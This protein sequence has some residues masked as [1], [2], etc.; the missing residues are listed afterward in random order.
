MDTLSESELLVLYPMFIPGWV[1]PVKPADIAHGGIPK[2]LY[3][4]Q[5]KG[6]E[7]LVDPWTELQMR[8]WTMAV[9]DRVDLYCNGSLV[10][11]AGQTVKP[12]EETLRQRLYLPHGNLK[13]GVNR[14]HYVVTRPGGGFET[15]R[16]LLVLYH[17]R[18]PENL[19]LVIPPDVIANGVDA[20]RAASGVEFGF[21]YANRQNHDRIEFRLGNTQVRFDVPDGTAPITHTLFTDTFQKVGDNLSAVVEFYVD[22]LL[23]NRVNSPEKRLYI[24]L[25]VAVIVPTLTNVLDT[26]GNEVQEAGTT[27]ST[28]LKLV[29]AASKGKE[30]EI[31]DGSGPS[32]VPKGKATADATTGVWELTITVAAGAH[33]LYAKSLYHSSNVY[34]NVRTLTVEAAIAPTIDSVK[35]DGV[36][37][38]DNTDT[39]STSVSLQGIVTSGRQVQIYDGTTPKHTVTAVGTTWST[40]LATPVGSYSITAKE[41]STGQV[42]NTRSFRVISPTLPLKIASLTASPHSHPHVF[43][44]GSGFPRTGFNGARF[45]IDVEAGVPP[46]TFSSSSGVNQIDQAGIVTIRG[47][48]QT[49]FTVRD[50]SGATT[51][52]TMQSLPLFFSTPDKYLHNYHY[53]SNGGRLPSIAQMTTATIGNPTQYIRAVGS[54]FGEWGNLMAGYGWPRGGVGAGQHYPNEHHYWT[55]QPTPDQGNFYVVSPQAGSVGALWRDWQIPCT[56]II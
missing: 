37:V 54:L 38:P 20:A 35:G 19:D 2:A 14:L 36:E 45:R 3:D 11:G 34:S 50:S 28:T 26:S 43:A 52:I 27:T 22:D 49:T 16:D 31:Y 7:C 8:S 24:H 44:I 17:L 40:T 46:Y 12:G 18:I 33:R 56:Y 6:L 29:G 32:A 48:D 4:G 42:S 5:T 25:A 53:A 30:V 10:S 51:A 41:V 23:G 55:S 47:K 39:K 21:T 15:S 13:H 1:S 9:D